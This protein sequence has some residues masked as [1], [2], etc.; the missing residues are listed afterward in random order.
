MDRITYVHFKS[1][2]P[3]VKAQVIKNRTGFYDA[4][5]QGIFCTLEEG[6]VDLPAVRDLLVSVGF[7]G[8]CT[9]EQDCDPEL[10]PD[11]LGDARK[12]REYLERIGF[13]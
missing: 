11:S 8:W 9:I 10:N 7:E 12:N 3:R 6:E 5:G 2:D 13:V 4:C 1:T